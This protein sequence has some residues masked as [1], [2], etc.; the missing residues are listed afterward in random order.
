M[1]LQDLCRDRGDETRYFEA[2]DDLYQDGVFLVP[3]G[4]IQVQM[5]LPHA[6]IFLSRASFVHHL[7]LHQ[8]IS[9]LSLSLS[10]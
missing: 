8:S 9:L 2:E 6:F 7:S 4:C 10:V 5:L 1:E 3:A